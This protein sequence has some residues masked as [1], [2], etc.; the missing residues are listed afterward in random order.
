MSKHKGNAMEY[1]S[2]ENGGMDDVIEAFFI[3]ADNNAPGPLKIMKACDFQCKNCGDCCKNENVAISFADVYRI[4]KF[5]GITP[6]EFYDKYCLWTVTH[7]KNSPEEDISFLGLDCR[8]GCPFHKDNRCSINEVKPLICKSYPIIEAGNIRGDALHR[9]DKCRPNCAVHDIPW[10]T[11]IVPDM[12]RLIDS[13]IASMTMGEY[14]LRVGGK[15]FIPRIVEGFYR[16]Q[17]MATKNK[18]VRQEAL[19][20]LAPMLA[21]TYRELLRMNAEGVRVTDIEPI[22]KPFSYEFQK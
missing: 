5:L 20:D 17:L 9:R 16:K 8:S 19:N 2:N 4:S 7:F 15:K 3:F 18:Q 13:Y 12:D 14:S 21:G 10:D 22:E 11:L 6:Q 1:I